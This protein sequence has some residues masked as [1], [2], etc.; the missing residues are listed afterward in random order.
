[1]FYAV[2]IN[3]FFIPLIF[4]IQRP[5]LLPLQLLPVIIAISLIDVLYLFPYYK[6]L[7]HADT[8]VVISLF[9]LGKI[10]VPVLAFLLVGEV[11]ALFQYLGFFLIVLSGTFLTLDFRRFRFT[12]AFWYMSLCSFLIALEVVLYKYSFGSVS[13][14]TS[15][16]WADLFSVLF[17]APMLLFPPLRHNIYDHFIHFRQKLPLFV[18][19]EFLTFTGMAALVIAISLTS[20]TIVNAIG[21]LQPFFV[22][23]YAVVLK[24]KIPAAFKEQ[25]DAFSMVRK[26]SLFAVMAIGVVL[27]FLP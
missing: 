7:Q 3:L 6:A 27:L 21:S 22:L 20:V 5:E 10:F 4:L 25:T 2:G 24:K 1:M 9:S 19:E 16:V 13:W 12:K 18:L 11:L 15:F 8:S 14:S 17:V 23:L 26:V